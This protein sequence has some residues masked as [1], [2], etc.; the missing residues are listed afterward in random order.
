MAVLGNQATGTTFSISSTFNQ[1]Q[2]ATKTVPSPGIMVEDIQ[3]RAAANG[4]ASTARLYVWRD[5]DGKWLIR[6]GTFSLGTSL[7]TVNRSDLSGNGVWPGLFIPAGTVIR[8]GIWVSSG[9]YNWTGASSG[10]SRIGQGGDG[11]YVN[12][13]DAVGPG[14]LTAWVDYHNMLNKVR[15]SGAWVNW[16]I[17]V[18]RSGVWVVP[19]LKVRRSGAWTVIQ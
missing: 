11:D 6:S 8:I 13:G 10:T 15:R 16:P 1:S 19:P 12:H 17:Q 4:S 14:E 5:S 3:V 18:R 2:G 9:N 7:T